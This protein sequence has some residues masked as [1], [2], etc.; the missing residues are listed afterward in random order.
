[1]SHITLVTGGGRSGK[2]RFALSMA[3]GAARRVFIATME[4]FDDESRDR[5]ARHRHERDAT[6][7]TVE[8][9][10]H[11]AEAIE[12]LPGDA[13]IAV[14][15]CLT[16][17]LGNLM[18]HLGDGLDA[19]SPEIV[20]FLDALGAPPCDLVIV[21]NEVGMGIIPDNALARRYRDLAGAVNQLV[22][23]RADQVVLIVSGCPVTLKEHE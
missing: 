15:D 10:V 8:A 18:H 3:E 4:P 20:A 1:M 14:I 21:T 11:L 6:W 12:S 16:V 17:W 13:E 19:D 9:P 23:A 2:S 7:T 22:A 5:I